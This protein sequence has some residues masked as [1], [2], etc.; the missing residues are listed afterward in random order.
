MKV[1]NYLDTKSV[2]EL[3][4]VVKREVISGK[5]GAPRFCM[6]VFEVESGSSTIP[7]THW[8]EHEVFVLSGRGLVVGEQGEIQIASDSVIF[9]APDEYHYFVNNGD[10]TLRY[11]LLNPLNP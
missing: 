3:L 7:H 6:L 10:E 8:W 11:I 4:G 1:S 2:E 9:I 5:D